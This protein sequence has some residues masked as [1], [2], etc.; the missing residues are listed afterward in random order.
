MAGLAASGTLVRHVRVRL[1]PMHTKSFEALLALCV[2]SAKR[3]KLDD[4]PWL[5]YR[6]PPGRYWLV[7]FGSHARDARESGDA[8]VDFARRVFAKENRAARREVMR[9]LDELEYEVEWNISTQQKRAWSTADDISTKTHPKARLMLRSV[10]PGAEKAFERALA[11]R[12]A[13]FAER[14]YPLPIEGF[15]VRRGLPGTAVQ[16]VFPTNWP[17]FHESL[18]FGRFVKS[19]DEKARADYAKRKQALMLTM[20]RAEFYDASFVPELSFGN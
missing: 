3:A 19:L 8:V 16:V 14:E 20:S 13:F 6:E 15:V 5:C 7:L 2:R 17:S 12:T 9:L 18:S 11:R 1:A 4:A 10:R